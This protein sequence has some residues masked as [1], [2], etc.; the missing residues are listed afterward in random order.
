MRL[1]QYRN[2]RRADG[3]LVVG[4]GSW[5]WGWRTE[6]GEIVTDGDADG[7][8]RHEIGDEEEV[9]LAGG[10]ETEIHVSKAKK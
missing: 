6:K 2:R 4:S 9:P 10:A 5:G 7:E 1:V 8:Y 3:A